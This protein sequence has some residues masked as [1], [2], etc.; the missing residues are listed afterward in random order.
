MSV[1]VVSIIVLKI[2]PTLL[3][4]TLVPVEVAIG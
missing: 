2:V 1:L 3:D 4:H